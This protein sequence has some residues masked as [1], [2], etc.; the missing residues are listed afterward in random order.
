MDTPARFNVLRFRLICQTGFI[1]TRA[2]IWARIISTFAR[3]R[4]LDLNR[5]ETRTQISQRT[6]TLQIFS[7][8]ISRYFGERRTAVCAFA[9]SRLCVENI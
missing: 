6:Q 4:K 3:T 7:V 1:R 5:K 2:T 9:S 8:F